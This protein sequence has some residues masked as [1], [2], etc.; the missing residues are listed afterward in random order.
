MNLSKK[1]LLLIH[2]V[3]FAHLSKH[4][5]SCMDSDSIEDLMDEISQEI[6]S[7]SDNSTA[8]ARKTCSPNR[9]ATMAVFGKDDDD[10]DEE[11]EEQTLE[12]CDEEGCLKHHPVE[13]VDADDFLK[14]DDLLVSDSCGNLRLQ[15]F[16][17]QN[18]LCA[19]LLN[20]R[21]SN[22]VLDTIKN[23]GSAFRSG[24]SLTLSNP[25][26]TWNFDVG[27][28]PKSWTSTLKPG[29]SYKIT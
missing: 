10:D 26:R 8:S 24:S 17:N 7:E 28:F 5:S 11:E 19:D 16:W 21:D 14:L 29:V 13:N 2:S 23:I 22:E 1:Q 4:D 27:K 9:V 12:V 20:P 3:L 18:K 15:F 25:S 6:L